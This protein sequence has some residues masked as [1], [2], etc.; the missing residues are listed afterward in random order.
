[1]KRGD[2]GARVLGCSIPAVTIPILS[3]REHH[4]E[5]GA[6]L[7]QRWCWECRL[8]ETR[9]LKSQLGTSFVGT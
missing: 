4:I 3:V 6:G 5:V 2:A 8:M 7:G 9:K 1:M